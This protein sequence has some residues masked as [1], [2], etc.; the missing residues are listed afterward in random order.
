MCVFRR[1]SDGV[2]TVFRRRS[3]G[4][5]TAIWRGRSDSKFSQP[6]KQ[7]LNPKVFRQH[8]KLLA[9][10]TKALLLGTAVLSAVHC[11]AVSAPSAECAAVWH[12][13]APCAKLCA[14]LRLD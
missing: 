5:P 11:C 13:V 3:D 8:R 4:V 1:R 6:A 14:G 12:H 7:T 9:G 2:P 10:K